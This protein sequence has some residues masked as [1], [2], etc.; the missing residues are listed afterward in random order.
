MKVFLSAGLSARLNNGVYDENHRQYLEELRRFLLKKNHKVFSAHCREQWGKKIMPPDLCTPLDYRGI[1][2]SDLVIAIVEKPISAG[3]CIELGWASALGKRI[4]IIQR[5]SELPA[6]I[7]GLKEI[8]DAIYIGDVEDKDRLFQELHLALF[9]HDQLS[10]SDPAHSDIKD[11]EVHRKVISAIHSLV[12]EQ[13][14]IGD[15]MRLESDLGL[16]SMAIIELIGRLE[17]YLGRTIRKEEL[18]L[19]DFRTVK[20]VIALANRINQKGNAARPSHKRRILTTDEQEVISSPT[21]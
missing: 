8:C 12:G 10:Y 20:S 6:L 18:D 14:D 13:I 21:D 1:R 2:E 9:H 7:V 3:V 5:T 17:V 11:D 15:E 16:N 4:L 19:T